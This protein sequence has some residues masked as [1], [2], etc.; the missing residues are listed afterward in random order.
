MTDTVIIYTQDDCPPCT[1]IKNYLVNKNIKF[2]EKNIKNQNYKNEM[3]DY[4][5]FATAFILLKGMP[6]YQVDMEKLND[7]LNITP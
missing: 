2:T 4:D 1:F 3:M 6:M 5:A 7:E